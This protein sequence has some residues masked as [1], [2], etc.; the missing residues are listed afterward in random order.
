[1]DKI[2]HILKID[3]FFVLFKSGFS[4]EFLLTS[5]AEKVIFKTVLQTIKERPHG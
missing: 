3:G 2:K 5:G 4:I 1:L